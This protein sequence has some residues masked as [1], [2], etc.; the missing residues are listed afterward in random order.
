MLLAGVHHIAVISKDAA[1]LARFYREVFDA[2]VAPTRPHGEH[3]EETM[4]VIAIAEHTELNVFTIPSSAEADRQ[5]PMWHRGRLDHFG[6]RASSRE[7][8]E[9]IRRRL[10][11]R[12][13]SDGTVNDFGSALSM[14]FRDPDGLEGEVLVPKENLESFLGRRAPGEQEGKCN[15]KPR[16]PRI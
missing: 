3:G 12:G 16:R 9:T 10:V 2:D 8:F 13:A 5:T 6:L 1:R 14:F 11:D 4:T 15:G 7:T